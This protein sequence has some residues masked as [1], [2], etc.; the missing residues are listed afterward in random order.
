M[1]KVIHLFGYRTVKIFFENGYGISIVRNDLY[2]ATADDFYEIALLQG[3]SENYF[4]IKDQI[5]RNLNDEQVSNTVKL[6][7]KTGE[8]GR[9]Y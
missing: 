3:D 9:D 5:Y 2:T 4:L 1:R 6:L 7:Q 8:T